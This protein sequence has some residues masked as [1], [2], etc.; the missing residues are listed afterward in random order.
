MTISVQ[1]V[2][3]IQ[4]MATACVPACPAYYISITHTLP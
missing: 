4:H 2:S 1:L 3:D